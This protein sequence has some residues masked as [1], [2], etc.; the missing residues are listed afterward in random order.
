VITQ[1]ESLLPFGIQSREY[2][3]MSQN[4]WRLESESV[5]G[6]VGDHMLVVQ[7]R[8]GPKVAKLTVGCADCGADIWT[9]MVN[10]D[11]SGNEIM[12]QSITAVEEHLRICEAPVPLPDIV[13]LS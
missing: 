9:A 8:R 4:D 10:Y 1:L 3:P 13:L 7:L 6:F 2:M 12:N 5:F 11:I